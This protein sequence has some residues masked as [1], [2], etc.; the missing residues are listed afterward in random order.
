M[1]LNEKPKKRTEQTQFGSVPKSN[2]FGL[3]LKKSA[4]IDP[5]RLMLTPSP[6]CR[7]LVMVRDGGE[8]FLWDRNLEV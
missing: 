3:I 1:G 7:R 6:V 8:Q 4:K 2:W 5:N